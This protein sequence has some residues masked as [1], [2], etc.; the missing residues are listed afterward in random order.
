VK[1]VREDLTTG[2]DARWRRYLV[3]V[4]DLEQGGGLVRFV[5]EGA[6]RR[7]Y[8]DSQIDDYQHLPRRR[9]PWRP[10]LEL[11]VRARFS[12]P[13]G[14]LLGTA[15]FGFWN[16]PFVMSGARMPALPR[17]LWFFYGSPPTNIKLDLAVPGWGWKAAT[18]DSLG[19]R[20]L[21]IAP[22]GPVAALLMN[23]PR[24]Y[25]ALWPRIQRVLRV[26]EAAVPAT[27]TDWHTYQLRWCGDET[28]F[29]VDGGVVLEH[30]PSPRGPLGFVMWLDNQYMVVTPQGRARWGRLD[31]P[32]RQWMEVDRLQIE[33]F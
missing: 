6:S 21:A 33:P 24:V 2:L 19:G 11:T 15:G 27:M 32:Q 30:A 5:L 23:I 18:I 17:A 16:D 22:L 10:P 25:Q 8:S 29:T 26:R 28:H 20:Q 9:F 1:P 12:H 13:A 31:V 7:R 14:T 3:G 4:G